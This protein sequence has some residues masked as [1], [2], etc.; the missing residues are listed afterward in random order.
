MITPA[1][2]PTAVRPAAAPADSPPDISFRDILHALNPLQ[3]VPVVGTIY[4]AITGD[5]VNEAVRDAGS[6]LVGGLLGGPIGVAISAVGALIQH[7]AHI[8]LD[9]MTRSAL[10]SAGVLDDTPQTV[11]EAAPATIEANPCGSATAAEARAQGLSAMAEAPAVST[12]VAIAAY[13]RASAAYAPG[14]GHA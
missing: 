14:P 2:A 10:V 8:D 9:A 7:F 4:R 3:Y 11:A 12:S 1:V 13:G 6:M 5:T